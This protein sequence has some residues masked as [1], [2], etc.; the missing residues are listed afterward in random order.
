MTPEDFEAWQAKP[1][2]DLNKKCKD[3]HK[4]LDGATKKAGDMGEAL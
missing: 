2:K 4:L 3:N 1:T